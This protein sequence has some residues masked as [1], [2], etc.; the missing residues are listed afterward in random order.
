MFLNKLFTY[1]TRAYQKVKG[2]LMGNHFHMKTKI[3]AKFQV[4]LRFLKNTI[5]MW[6]HRKIENSCIGVFQARKLLQ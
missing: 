4:P 3:L 2:V 1:L 6:Y 5:F